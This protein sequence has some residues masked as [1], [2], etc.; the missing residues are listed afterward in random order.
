MPGLTAG[1]ITLFFS[2]AIKSGCLKVSTIGIS[3][4]ILLCYERQPCALEDAKD[5]SWPL[6]TY[7]YPKVSRHC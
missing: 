1:D 2:D 5:H 4:P 3:G 6:P 7:D